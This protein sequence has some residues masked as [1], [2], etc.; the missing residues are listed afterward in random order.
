MRAPKNRSRRPPPDR[1][2]AQHD[3][4]DGQ[5]PGPA[6]RDQRRSWW[7]DP[8]PTP[9]PPQAAGL[10]DGEIADVVGNVALNVPACY[11]STTTDN[12]TATG[13]S[14]LLRIFR[15]LSAS[16]SSVLAASRLRAL[17]L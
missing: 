3:P 15:R 1:R 9:T 16:S 8:G 12:P 10:D 4:G 5:Q 7:P 2:H 11:F 6:Q 17:Q 13:P 14:S